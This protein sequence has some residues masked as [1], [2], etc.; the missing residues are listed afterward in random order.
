MYGF[1][2]I[3]INPKS[4]CVDD[5][6]GKNVYYGN[7]PQEVLERA[8]NGICYAKLSDV[9][10]GGFFVEDDESGPFQCIIPKIGLSYRKFK[11]MQEFL[12]YAYKNAK[13]DTSNEYL[14]SVGIWVKDC[15]GNM[16]QVNVIEGTGIGFKGCFYYWDDILADYTFLNGERCGVYE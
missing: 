12:E 8:N 4:K 5:L 11:G 16:F 7:S 9:D 10:D 15:E 14:H 1:D 2:D 6:F 13:D 3:L